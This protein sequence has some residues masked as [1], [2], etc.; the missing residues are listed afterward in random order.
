MHPAKAAGLAHQDPI[1]GL[2]GN[3]EVRR[4]GKE[5]GR[6]VERKV[7]WFFSLWLRDGP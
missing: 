6:Y 1:A 5:E 4:E 7:P 3:M 2:N